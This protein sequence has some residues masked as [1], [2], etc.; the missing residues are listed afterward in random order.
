MKDWL[1]N[2]LVCYAAIK[3]QKFQIVVLAVDDQDSPNS[4]VYV[5][6]EWMRGATVLLIDPPLI[7]ESYR[8]LI[9]DMCG[10][11]VDDILLVN[12]IRPSPT[13]L[14]DNLTMLVVNFPTSVKY[15][16]FGTNVDYNAV[17]PYDYRNNSNA[18]Y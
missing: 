1:L 9:D 15:P 12:S 6:R 16:S 10:K 18:W 3:N 17:V 2:D 8:R 7:N 13:V 11:R 5:Y 14:R 4:T